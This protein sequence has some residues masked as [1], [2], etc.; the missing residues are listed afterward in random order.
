MKSSG[1]NDRVIR[2]DVIREIVKDWS[3]G[4]VATPPIE[5]PLCGKL[6]R[7]PYACQWSRTEWGDRE[8]E[9]RRQQQL[10]RYVRYDTE[11][12]NALQQRE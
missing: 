1:E 9:L 10:S 11:T 12:Q 2:D 6:T 4:M 5:C 8:S 3:V 7:A